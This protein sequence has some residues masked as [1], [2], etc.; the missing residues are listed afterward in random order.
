[1]SH[2][3]DSMAQPALG[4][5]LRRASFPG[6]APAPQA[7]A[8]PAAL[9]HRQASLRNALCRR[10]APLVIACASGRVQALIGPPR[11]EAADSLWLA[12]EV[13]GEAAALALPPSLLR[14]LC[15]QALDAAA[16]AD[17]ALLLEDALA[18]WLDASEA[19]TGLSLRFLGLGPH[20][21]IPDAISVA[22]AI[23]TPPPAA[24]A[25]LAL[26]LSPAAAE[27]LAAAMRR[28]QLP[29][30]EL[31]GMML[32]VAIEVDS[33][34]LS[35]AELQS[36]HPGDALLLEADPPPGALRV[37]VENRLI[38]PVMAEPNDMTPAAPD[39]ARRWRMMAALTPRRPQQ[40]TPL[41]ADLH[42][43]RMTTDNPPR[44]TTPS[45]SLPQ[46]QAL[47]QQKARQQHP[48]RHPRLRRWKCGCPFA[49]V[50]R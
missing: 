30:P 14:R 27:R 42:E 32:R 35:L 41:P 5:D 34:R 4:L 48:C 29:R 1:M 22:L 44:P 33:L 9:N 2:S 8:L 26:R 38:A 18:D 28:W 43:D 21:P 16:P 50:R 11:P 31:A 3:D 23:E 7:T 13:D 17:A 45:R 19:L 46:P 24:R 47:F 25:I 40:S 20:L 37:V 39:T 15:G 36:L 49:S 6:L 12:L 10:H